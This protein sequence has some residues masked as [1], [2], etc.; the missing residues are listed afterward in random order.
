MPTKKRVAGVGE[1]GKGCEMDKLWFIHAME[2]YPLVKT[3]ELDLCLSTCGYLKYITLT[4]KSKF[5]KDTYS[6]IHSYTV[7][8][9]YSL[10]FLLLHMYLMKVH[11]S[12][13]MY[14]EIR[15]IRRSG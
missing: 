2:Y 8:E 14:M 11:I 4:E 1:G 10:H 13:R 9:E 15:H 3:N 7:L 6:M 12:I 5:S